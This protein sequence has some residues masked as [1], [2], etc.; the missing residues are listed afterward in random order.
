MPPQRVWLL[1]RFGLKTGMGFDRYGLKS[2]MVFKGTTRA[3]KGICLFNSKW[4]VEKEKYPKYIV[5]TKFYQFS[6]SLP[7]WSLIGVQ[8]RSGNGYGFESPGLKTGV[9]NGIFWSE[10][11]SGF[12]EPGGTPL[13]R[14]P[15]SAAPPP[16]GYRNSF[17]IV[18]RNEIRNLSWVILKPTVLQR[19]CLSLGIVL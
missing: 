6:T 17:L 10:I 18:Q 14:I 3:Y 2:G 11:G 12:G 5:R 16:P 4:I 15:R 8:Q 9:E 19:V 13:P 7:M 1:S